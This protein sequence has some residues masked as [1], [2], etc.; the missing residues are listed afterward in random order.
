MDDLGEKLSAILS[1]PG[2]LDKI[3]QMARSIMGGSAPK[4]APEETAPAPPGAPGP[5]PGL[6][7]DPAML[8]KLAGLLRRS[9]AAGNDKRA[10]LEAMKPYLSEKRR[11]KMDKAMK[12]AKLASFA[13]LAAREFGG[14]DDV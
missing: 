1:D 14:G 11:K 7:L 2:Q 3:A 4:G 6:D 5:E 8:G 13:E 9:G 12:L 10:L